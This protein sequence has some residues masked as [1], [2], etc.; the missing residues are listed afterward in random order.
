VAAPG[1]VVQLVGGRAGQSRAAAWLGALALA[2]TVLTPPFL[3]QR[4]RRRR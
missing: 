3:L 4:H 2:L 1:Q